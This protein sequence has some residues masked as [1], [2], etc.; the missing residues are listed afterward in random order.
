MIRQIC[1]GVPLP[2]TRPP[3]PEVRGL[4]VPASRRVCLFHG[5]VKHT[6]GH[7]GGYVPPHTDEAPN[8]REPLRGEVRRTPLPRIPVDRDKWKGWT[9]FSPIGGCDKDR[10]TGRLPPLSGNREGQHPTPGRR[11]RCEENRVV[12]GRHGDGAERK[13]RGGAGRRG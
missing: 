10:S 1:A 11:V 2:A 6:H 7:E 13:R 8:F 9:R 12:V 5:C 4:C 3:P